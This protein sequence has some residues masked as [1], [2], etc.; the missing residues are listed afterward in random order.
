M[1]LWYFLEIPSDKWAADKAESLVRE[2]HHEFSDGTMRW[3]TSAS[4]GIVFA[5]E[6]GNSFEI[7]YR[8]SEKALYLAKEKGKGVFYI[9]K[10]T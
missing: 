7:L 8:D 3:R 2:L 5:P 1:S 4:I 10:E 6:D 9:S